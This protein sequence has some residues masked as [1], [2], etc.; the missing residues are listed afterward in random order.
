MNLHM[1]TEPIPKAEPPVFYVYCV[2]IDQ[3][4]IEFSLIH[5]NLIIKGL[6]RYETPNV[7]EQSYGIV[8][9]S[10]NHQNLNVT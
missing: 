8:K 10:K 5:F 6:L 7:Q 2:T 3:C 1:T 9:M 4:I